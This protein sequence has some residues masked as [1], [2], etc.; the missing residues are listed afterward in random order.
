MEEENKNNTSII[1]IGT[2]S[3][4]RVWNSLEITKKLLDENTKREKLFEE[5]NK[6]TTPLSLLYQDPIS[7]HYITIF[8]SKTPIPVS[9]TLLIKFPFKN[10]SSIQLNVSLG[11][12]SWGENNKPVAKIQIENQSIQTHTSF[13]LNFTFAIDTFGILSIIVKD[14]E[15]ETSNN[16]KIQ[17]FEGLSEADIEKMKKDNANRSSI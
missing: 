8:E 9:K 7:G 5:I 11:E 1:P 2:N 6:D 13:I 16:I 4:V 15:K 14:N 12:I 3:L 17:A 10:Q